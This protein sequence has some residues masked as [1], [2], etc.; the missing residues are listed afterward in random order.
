ME[1]TEGSQKQSQLE[2][3][4]AHALFLM[5]TKVDD[6]RYYLV[7]ANYPNIWRVTERPLHLLDRNLNLKGRNDAY[8]LAWICDEIPPYQLVRETIHQKVPRSF[9][10]IIALCQ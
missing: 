2:K 7:C 4:M 8:R 5:Y 6:S 10:S 1:E 3:D 9:S